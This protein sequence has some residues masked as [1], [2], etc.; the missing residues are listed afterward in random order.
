MEIVIIRPPLVYGP[1]VRANFLKLMKLV[2]S[3][4]PLP[5]GAIHNS[6]SFVAVDNLVDLILICLHHP[7][8]I[9]QTFLVSDGDDLSTTELLR[10]TA[11][12][13]GKSSRLIPI[14]VFLLRTAALLLGK[15]DFVQRLCGSLQIDISKA[16]QLLGW[17]PKVSVDEALLKTAK[18]FLKKNER[19]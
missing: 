11:K 5:F 7:A 4:L 18:Y 19:H 13:F 2:K 6:R 3:G 9:N 15:A 17:T 8:A 12:A 16:K 1:E 10:R 14:P